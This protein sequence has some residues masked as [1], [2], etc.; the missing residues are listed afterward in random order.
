[1][2]YLNFTYLIM[3]IEN[4]H[5]F[6]CII[7][8][9]IFFTSLTYFGIFRNRLLMG[10]VR[11]VL[12]FF[13]TLNCLLRADTS[14]SGYALCSVLLHDIRDITWDRTFSR[15]PALKF[16]KCGFELAEWIPCNN[17]GEVVGTDLFYTS[18]LYLLTERVING[19][20]DLIIFNPFW[21]TS[22]NCNVITSSL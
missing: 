21:L 4:G 14:L 10:Q 17:C 18:D 16:N 15:M 5:F 2:C 13:N 3:D 19:I 1:M 22:W 8:Y 7:Q 20:L 12:N 11:Q 9:F 6:K